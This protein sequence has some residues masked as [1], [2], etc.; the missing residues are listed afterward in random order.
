MKIITAVLIAAMAAGAA[1]AQEDGVD[2]ARR[3]REKLGSLRL[4]VDFSNAKVADVIAYFR[5]YSGLNFH[6]D[7]DVKDDAVTMKLKNVTLRTALKLVLGPRDL[8]CVYRGGVL[9][10]TPKAKL[11][12]QAVTRIYDVRDL[13]FQLQDFPGPKFELGEKPG[14]D[15]G[16]IFTDEPKVTFTEDVIVDLIK[17]NVGSRGWDESPGVSI[18]LANGL[19]VVSQTPAIHEEVRG[20]LD[21]LRQYK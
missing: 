5:E 8:G 10:I 6:L 4:D 16:I 2:P 15:P 12:T 1:R 11:D 17:T 19:L 3:T 13:Q 20:F 14:L 21:R 9:L 7:A 18:T